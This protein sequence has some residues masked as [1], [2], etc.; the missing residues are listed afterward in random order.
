M[1]SMC[2]WMVV[3]LLLAG[4]AGCG[5]FGEDGTF[6][7]RSGDYRQAAHTPPLA[8]PP[9]SETDAIQDYYSVPEID[10]HN[11]VEPNYEVPRPVRLVAG[12]TDAMVKI[13][14]LDNQRWILVRLVPGQVWPRLRDFLLVN[15]LGIEVEDG[16]SGIIATGWL[17]ADDNSGMMERYQ[18]QL[19]QGLQRTTSEI[20][21][22]N[23]EVPAP[24]EGTNITEPAW[25]A[26][27]TNPER[28]KLFL[29]TLA[30]FLAENSDVTAA[31]SLKA[32]DINT[33]SRMY[34]E[35]EP[36]PRIMVELSPERAWAS[37]GYSLDKAG[38]T[39][40]DRDQGKGIYDVTF[41]GRPDATDERGFW[42]KL[43]GLDPPN[44]GTGG[45]YR[46]LLR[47]SDRPGW[48]EIRVEKDGKFPPA[49]MELVISEIK[50]YMT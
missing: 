20:Y 15:R 12:D 50:G 45:K 48:M 44:T 30:Q 1:M 21:V 47:A 3:C 36:A 4:I 38:F 2:R 6:R 9:E 23:Q 39:I 7:D 11:P 19:R 24:A 34:V 16:K 40:D 14:S 5:I 13:Q 10:N 33:A 25:P 46:V 32:Q 28:E 29:D 27:S 31:V 26:T 41:V 42:S 37:L 35:A 43:F 49:E 18:F 8:L 17:V 22:L